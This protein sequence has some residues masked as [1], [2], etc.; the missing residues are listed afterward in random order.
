MASSIPNKTRIRFTHGDL[1]LVN[2]IM[3]KD[4]SSSHWLEWQWLVSGLLGSTR[5]AFGIKSTEYE[6]WGDFMNLILSRRLRATRVTQFF[7][8]AVDLFGEA[9]PNWLDS[10]SREMTIR[11]L[12]ACRVC[13]IPNPTTLL[14][15]SQLQSQLSQGLC[16]HFEE[17]LCGDGCS[18]TKA[19]KNGTILEYIKKWGG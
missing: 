2:I 5:D 18:Q 6:D 14:V 8:A 10:D 12:S 3:T 11:N 16:K 1:D 9:N 17:V 4:I 19:W 13:T 15:L 7:G